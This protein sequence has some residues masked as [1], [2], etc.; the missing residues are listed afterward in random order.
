M[1]NNIEYTHLI[2]RYGELFLKGKNR[3]YFEKKLMKN[4]KKI[5][6]Q[7][8]LTR[9]QGRII[10]N[11][12]ENHTNLQKVFGLKSYSPSIK[13][14]PTLDSIKKE[15]LHFFSKTK[16]MFRVETK[17]SDKRFPYTSQETNKLVGGYI[18]EHST[19]INGN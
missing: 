8:F 13:V 9:T 2:I 11:Y 5:T 3:S 7:E 4:I 12:Y 6:H 14:E 10:M 19:N 16:G 1:L 17:R 15:A 18:E